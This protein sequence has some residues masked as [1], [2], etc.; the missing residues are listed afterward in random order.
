MNT[1]DSTRS[2]VMESI[3]TNSINAITL[4]LPLFLSELQPENNVCISFLHSM[5]I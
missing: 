2:A 3:S 1:S 4:S 5:M